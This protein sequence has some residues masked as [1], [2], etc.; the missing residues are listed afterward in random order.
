MPFIKQEASSVYALPLNVIQEDF[1]ILKHA[2]FTD[3][4]D[5]GPWNYHAWLMSLLCPIQVVAIRYLAEADGKVGF[6]LG[7]SHQV[8]NFDHL[9]I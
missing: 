5:Q 1:K 4:K 9:D 2:Y 6:A 3:P 7:L 8:K